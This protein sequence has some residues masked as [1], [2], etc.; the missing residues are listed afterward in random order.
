MEILNPGIIVLIL[1]ILGMIAVQ[2]KYD[3]VWFISLCGA[4]LLCGFI[5][6]Y[7]PIHLSWWIIGKL[8]GG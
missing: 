2:L 6:N 3:P 5:L 1:I 8:F 4:G 7:L